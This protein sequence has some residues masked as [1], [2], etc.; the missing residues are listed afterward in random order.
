MDEMRNQLLLIRSLK[1]SIE[2]NDD[3][4]FYFMQLL[5]RFEI[6]IKRKKE[7]LE[8]ELEKVENNIKV[9]EFVKKEVLENEK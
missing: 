8:H 1:K 6:D 2:K 5:E 7:D 3:I 9:L 4:E